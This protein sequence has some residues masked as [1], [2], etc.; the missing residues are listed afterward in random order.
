M[1]TNQEEISEHSSMLKGLPIL[2]LQTLLE[3]FGQSR[4][5]EQSALLERA[6]EL[7]RNRPVGFNYQA[8]LMKIQELFQCIQNQNNPFISDADSYHRHNMMH[9]YQENMIS[10]SRLTSS[11]RLFYPTEPYTPI[12]SYDDHSIDLPVQFKK[13]PFYDYIEEVLQ[14]TTLCGR[15]QCTLKNSPKGMREITIRMPL[16]CRYVNQVAM[17][18]IVSN[19]E[20]EYPYQI[21]TRI[22]ELA[23]GSELSD[24]LPTSLFI[25]INGKVLPLPPLC[26]NSRPGPEARRLPYPLNF[27]PL[28]KLNPNLENI[29]RLNWIPD[30]KTYILG[31]NL[32][33][34]LSPD[35][36]L[37]RLSEKGARSTEETKND[38]I[39]KL[40]EI[41]PEL[42]T[43]SY[44]V[45]I[46]CPLSQ[47]RMKIPAKSIKCDHL[48]CFDASTFILMNEKKPKWI[49]PTC[50]NTC[51]F[52]DIR[53]QSYFLEIV[54][55]PSLPDTCK[56][57]E[58]IADGTWRV[59]DKKNKTEN[60]ETAARK[61]PRTSVYIYDSDDNKS[62]KSNGDSKISKPDCL[63]ETKKSNTFIDLTTEDERT[64][65]L[66]ESVVS[67]ANDSSGPSTSRGCTVDSTTAV[68]VPTTC[69]DKKDSDP[70]NI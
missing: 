56:E 16:A 28:L 43:T 60:T 23:P 1:S 41:D 53:I 33:E 31:I 27:T 3:L 36:L 65:R 30:G 59:F 52:D 29:A 61:K 54:T 64:I 24:Y 12:I 22:C 37:K 57:I 63:E 69:S 15:E 44:R 70:L 9:T 17:N 47:M 20:T 32:V 49:C 55:S 58:I 4:F 14:P 38:I 66:K 51:L 39:Q 2:E 42:S 18:R 13:L 68:A 10:M 25:R 40:A 19:G 6:L 45:S 67:E 46:V 62:D 26:P 35:V 21:Q 34:K 48:Q 8:Y 50:N 7:L 5:G 11:P